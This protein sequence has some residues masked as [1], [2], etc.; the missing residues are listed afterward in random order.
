MASDLLV[1]DELRSQGIG[2][3]LLAAMEQQAHVAGYWRVGLA[4]AV[5]NVRARSLYERLG[6]HDAGFEA[7]LNRWKE[8]DEHG[9]EAWYEERDVYMVRNLSLT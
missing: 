9:G 2:T 5:D 7:Y 3:Q 1:V 6:Y 8:T 4:V